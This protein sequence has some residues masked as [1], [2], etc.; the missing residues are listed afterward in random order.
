MRP[1]G[2]AICRMRRMVG[3]ISNP[4][5]DLFTL[6]CWTLL[7][8][9]K[10]LREKASWHGDETHFCKV[11]H[12]ISLKWCKMSSNKEILSGVSNTF[13]KILLVQMSSLIQGHNPVYLFVLGL[14][15]GVLTY[16]LKLVIGWH[17]PGTQKKTT[18]TCGFSVA[19]RGTRTRQCV[20]PIFPG[21]DHQKIISKRTGLFTVSGGWDI[22]TRF[23]L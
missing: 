4:C 2:A 9:M 21:S 23:C 7:Q 10:E 6:W 3:G 19:I 15:I 5:R 13:Q 22:A 20:Y 18:K 8:L 16:Y 11:F 14:F 17:H 1:T 12:V